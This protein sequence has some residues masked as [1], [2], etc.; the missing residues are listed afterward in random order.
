V[1]YSSPSGHYSLTFPEGFARSEQGSVVTFTDKL[2]T[3]R[4]EVIAAAAAPTVASVT[5]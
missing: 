1:S 5:Q 3:I 4:V 2:N